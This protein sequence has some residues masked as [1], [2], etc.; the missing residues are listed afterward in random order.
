[1]VRV[2]ALLLTVSQAAQALPAGTGR[3]TFAPGWRLTPNDTFA[4]SAELA[5]TPLGHSLPGG[6]VGIASFAYAATEELEV[7]LSMYGGAEFLK[8]EGLPTLTSVTYGALAG[9]RLG[10]SF[11]EDRVRPSL[12]FATG[13]ALVM[14][15]GG[16]MEGLTEKLSQIYVPGVGVSFSLGTNWDLTLDYRLLLAVRGS[17][18]GIGSING[19][20]SWFTIGIS[21]LFPPDFGHPPRPSVP[22][23]EGS[24]M[25][26]M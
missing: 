14:T 25:H 15:T 11:W 9:L 17:V 26:M 12:L 7:E 5:G 21:Y 19:G 24:G 13:I 16:G 1:M 22:S 18:P 3:I 2:L 10:Y 4:K 6:P 8:L 23:L 20:G